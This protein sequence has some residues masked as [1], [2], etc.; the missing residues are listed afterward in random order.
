[1]GLSI[2]SK[3]LLM[4]LCGSLLS[5]VVIGAIGYINGRNSLQDAAINQ[6]TTIRETRALAIERELQSIQTGV[7]LDSRN[8]SAVQGA[9]AFIDGFRELQDAEISPDQTAALER[10]YADD[11]VPRLEERSGLDYDAETFIPSSNAGRYVQANYT[12]GRAYDD[13]DGGLALTDAGDGSAWTQANV[14]YGPYFTGLVDEL[15]YEDV[16]ILDAEANVVFSAF[17]SV[18]MG[19]NL[20]EEPYASSSLTSAFD[21]VMRNGSLD[22]VE[23]TD[24]EGYLPSLNVPTAWV[25]SPLGSSTS[26]EGALAVQVPIDQIDAVATGEQG[27]EEQGLGE[28]GEVYIAGPDGLMRSVSRSLLED[29][30]AYERAVTDNGTPTDVAQRAVEVNGTVLLQPVDTYATQQALQ[31]KTGTAVAAEYNESDSLVAYAP[32]EIDGL[33]WVIVAHIDQGEAFAPVDRFARHLLLSTFA[34]VLVISVLSVAFAQIFT[35]PV[36]RLVEAVRRV[37]GGELAVQVPSRSRDEFGDL[38]EAFNDMAESLRVKQELIDEQQE[39]NEHLL[40]T[41]MPEGV[42]A[43]YKQ[44][45]ET[46]AEQRDDVSVVFAELVGFDDLT[47]RLSS[48]DET[49][50]LNQLM[51]GF[52]E[53]AEKAGVEKVRTLRGGYL[54]SSGLV[55]P[56]IDNVRR[57]VDFTLQM[58]EVVARFN[59]QH[60][61]D[62]DLRAGVDTGVVSSGL[63]ARTN[64]AYDLWGDAVSLA[65]RVRAVT[66]SPGI[67]VSEAV[68]ERLQ[69]AFEF[70]DVG[71]IEVRGSTQRVWMVRAR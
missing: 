65:H 40:H 2:Q 27:W 36:K 34:I 7:R 47:E 22:Q 6:L 71:T 45:E 31:G 1:M 11:F 44:G 55:V 60:G 20:R 42:A 63:V 68:R 54:V 64:M 13:F 69:D 67:Y 41:L 38:G 52:D 28:T 35:R 25:V 3:L 21:S 14:E 37:A 59:A 5:S 30:E 43:R 8:A 48:E 26:L 57:A 10:Y 9:Q 24:Y 23:T 15:G 56:R 51:R 39:E 49:A 66:G 17:K 29:P 46:I 18:D 70:D 16:L 50:L 53:A 12:V 58:R 61:T 19:A 32:L 62:L 33:N 4:L